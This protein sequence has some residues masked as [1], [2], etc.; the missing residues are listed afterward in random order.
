MTKVLVQQKFN[1]A[2]EI[3]FEGFLVM[4]KEAL[5][6]HFRDVE[7]GDPEYSWSEP[8]EFPDYESIGSNQEI[9]IKDM[10][11][12]KSYFVVTEITDE[13]ALMLKKLFPHAFTYGFGKMI[14]I[15]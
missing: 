10:D 2:D 1:W 11:D 3:N 13:E 9:T 14:W 6:K 4:E 8:T 15:E 7:F 5:E 12:Y